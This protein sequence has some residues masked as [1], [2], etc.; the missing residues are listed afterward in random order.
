VK[1]SSIKKASDKGGPDD[2]WYI[3]NSKDIRPYSICVK[4]C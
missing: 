1:P 4:K 2:Y 3:E